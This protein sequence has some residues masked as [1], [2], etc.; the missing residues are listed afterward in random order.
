MTQ[1]RGKLNMYDRAVFCLRIQGDLD[2]SWSEYFDIQSV[3]V[4]VDESG[5]P[6]TTLIS[7]P[8]DQ[9]ALVGMIN[10]LNALGIPLISVECLPAGAVLDQAS[11]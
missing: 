10:H 11:N 9:C 2:E 1:R 4:C 3:A 7:A 6:T 8:V 5:S